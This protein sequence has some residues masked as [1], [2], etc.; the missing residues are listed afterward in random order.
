[1]RSANWLAGTLR[2][3]GFPT[4]AVWQTG[5]AP[6]V[7]AEWCAAPDAPTVLVYSHHD[8]R[9]AKDWQW[10]ETPPFEPALRDGRLY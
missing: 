2:D 3:T 5:G 1:L 7:Y 6:A 4:V 9:A 10:E 8:V